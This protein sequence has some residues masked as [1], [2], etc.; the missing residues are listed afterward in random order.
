LLVLG[1]DMRRA[2]S[3]LEAKEMRAL[4][5]ERRKL[6]SA[7][8]KDAANLAGELDKEVNDSS[9]K[10]LQATL[11]AAVSDPAASESLR[12]GNLTKALEY[13]GFGPVDLTDAVAIPIEDKERPK[14]K[15][16]R[17]RP[18]TGKTEQRSTSSATEKREEKRTQA[19]LALREAQST[20]ANAER[21]TQ[22]EKARLDRASGELDR[23]TEHMQK[24]EKQ[25]DAMQAKAN[26]TREAVEEAK[27]AVAGAV[28]SQR[29]AADRVSRAEAA[30]DR[31]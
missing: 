11:E 31:L 13:S 3:K 30:L 14:A 7:L 27:K 29:A 1:D 15:S 19:K 6:V 24:L 28:R 17:A 23:L 10:E 4:A 12:S 21:S 22:I 9:I 5:D 8:A 25:L 2:Q 20:Q 16:S 26:E 18:P